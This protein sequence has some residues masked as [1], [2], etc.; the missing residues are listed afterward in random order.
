MQASAIRG[1]LAYQHGRDVVADF[2]SEKASEERG[3]I[4]SWLILA[5]GLAIAAGA[6][7]ALLGPW[8]GTKVTAI[9]SN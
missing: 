5:A 7:V 2:V 9:T 3:E 6:A 4:G 8:L 1:Y